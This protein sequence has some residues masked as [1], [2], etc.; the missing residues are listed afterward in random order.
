MLLLEPERIKIWDRLVGRSSR[1]Q[2]EEEQ[3]MAKARAFLD[4]YGMPYF[5]RFMAWIDGRI[6]EQTPM[7]DQFRM[8]AGVARANAFKE[9]KQ[10]LLELERRAKMALED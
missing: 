2:D 8:V 6:E 1:D 9:I 4:W 3:E 10:Y 7:D 5:P